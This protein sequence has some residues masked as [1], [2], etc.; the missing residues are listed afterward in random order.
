VALQFAASVR[1]MGYIE[2]V[3]GSDGDLRRVRVTTQGREWLD[4]HDRNKPTLHPRYSS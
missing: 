1:E 3:G 4:E 2:P